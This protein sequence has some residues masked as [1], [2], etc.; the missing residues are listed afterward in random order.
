MLRPGPVGPVSHSPRRQRLPA[1]SS[2]SCASSAA[3]SWPR[4]VTAARIPSCARLRRGLVV[5][6]WPS[7][8][9]L[10]TAAAPP[11]FSPLHSPLLWCRTPHAK[12]S[13]CRVAAPGSW[14]TRRCLRRPHLCARSMLRLERRPRSKPTLLL[15]LRVRL[16]FL[17]LPRLPQLSAGLTCPVCA[18]AP[19]VLVVPSAA[20]RTP[21]NRHGRPQLR[22]VDAAPGAL[23]V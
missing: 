7:I 9:S 10:P 16:C 3:S 15:R 14:S 20:P 18:P 1:R 2:C 12:A 8:S 21:R 4:S 13:P 19:P 5:S 11:P 23:L 6:S 22:A 17:E